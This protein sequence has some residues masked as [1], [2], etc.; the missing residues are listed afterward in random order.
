M[1]RNPSEIA[2]LEEEYKELKKEFKDLRYPKGY[3]EEIG[4]DMRK[5]ERQLGIE[6][7]EYNKYK[8]TGTPR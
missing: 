5:V 1:P 7:E 2:R 6:E 8:P 3:R 4:R